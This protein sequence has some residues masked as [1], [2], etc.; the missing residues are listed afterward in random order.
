MTR[1]RGR[2]GP[3][4][5]GLTVRCRYCQKTG[6][7]VERRAP[8][9]KAVSWE[10]GPGWLSRA[11][12]PSEKLMPFSKGLLLNSPHT[13]RLATTTTALGVPTRESPDSVPRWPRPGLSMRPWS[14]PHLAIPVSVRLLLARLGSCRG[15]VGCGCWQLRAGPGAGTGGLSPQ[16]TS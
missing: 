15:T 16:C 6:P 10:W 5:R 8:P 2:Q 14:W 9:G 7:L 13:E 11:P 12:A 1:L 4:P 3:G